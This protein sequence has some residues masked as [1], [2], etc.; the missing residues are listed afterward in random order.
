MKRTRRT[1]RGWRARMPIPTRDPKP[2]PPFALRAWAAIERLDP[3]E[4]VEVL[5]ELGELDGAADRQVALERLAERLGIAPP[6]HF[7]V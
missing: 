6:D 1:R 4:Q 2:P 7:G 3:G 5:R